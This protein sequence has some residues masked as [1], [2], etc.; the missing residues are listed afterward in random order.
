MNMISESNM[1]ALKV[2]LAIISLIAFLIVV[3]FGNST[4]SVTIAKAV[5]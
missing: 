4:N 2:G 3:K 5:G 1:L